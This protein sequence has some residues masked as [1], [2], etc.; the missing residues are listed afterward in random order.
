MTDLNR[1]AAYTLSPKGVR[2]MGAALMLC[3]LALPWVYL[4]TYRP[5]EPPVIQVGA[6]R[7]EMRRLPPGRFL[8][9]SAETE[10]GRGPN[11]KQHE[12][13]IK[14]VFAI[15]VTEVTQ[16][17]YER[18]MGKNP[19]EAQGNPEKPV[20]N[21]SWLDAVEYCNRLSVKENLDPCYR[22]E[23]GKVSWAEG[24]RCKGYRLPTEAEWEYAARADGKTK[25]AGSDELDA[26]AWWA[27]NAQGST[28]QVAGKG[29]NGWGL[30]DFS[31][32]VW[33]WVW[34]W[35]ESRYEDLPR[36][37]PIGPNSGSYRVERGGSWYN[38]AQDARVAY[39]DDDGPG[40]RDALQGFRLARSY[41]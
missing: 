2:G 29:A 27:S 11:E 21:V 38:D 14:T 41:H 31:G 5:K 1:S 4:K 7:P 19:S 30:Y 23:G 18:V 13:E 40:Y 22:I 28:H 10:E 26:V 8:M 32:N 36:V 33:E 16:G 15:A 34:D 12:V 17:Q 39:R 37:D 3:G 35:Y 9:G 20:E 25:Y 24:L 6:L